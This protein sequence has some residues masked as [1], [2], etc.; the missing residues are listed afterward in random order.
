M[1]IIESSKNEKHFWARSPISFE[2]MSLC[3]PILDPHLTTY[4]SNKGVQLIAM[5][6]LHTSRLYPA[7]LMRIHG[8]IDSLTLTANL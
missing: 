6:T 8:H 2:H 1:L 4:Q 7:R 5:L 3:Y